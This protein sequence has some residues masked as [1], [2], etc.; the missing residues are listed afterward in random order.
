M[1]NVVPG[2]LQRLRAADIIRMAG[3]TAASLGQEYSRQGAVHQPER[4]G[5][6]LSGVIDTSHIS[7]AGSQGEDEEEGAEPGRH[8]FT[9]EVDIKSATSWESRCSCNP[10]PTQLCSHAASL[11]YYWLAHPVAFTTAP[12]TPPPSEAPKRTIHD[13]QKSVKTSQ[14]AAPVK[15]MQSDPVPVGDLL[16]MLEQMG[17]SDLRA[18]AREYDIIPNGLSRQHLAVSVQEALQQPEA[19][20]HVATTLEKAQRQLLAALILAGGVMSDDDLRGLYERFSLGQPNQYQHILMALQNKALLVRA[21]LS[22]T[23]HQRV[24]S[25]SALFDVGWY[26]PLEVRTALRVMVPVTRFQIESSEEKPDVQSSTPLHLLA[27]LLLVARALAGYRLEQQ[28]EWLERKAG[29]RANETMP[30]LR[31]PSNS[32]GS[33]PIPP[34]ADTPS[35][36]M[37]AFLQSSLKQPP[38]FLRLALHLLSMAGIV[39]QD[40]SGSPYLRVLPDAAQLLL[41]PRS[42]EAA[43]DLF[44][45]WLTRS[46][47]DALFELQEEGVRLRCRATSLNI[48]L[49]RQGDLDVEN[50][51]AL[52]LVVELLAQAPSNQWISFPA[53]ARFFY[54]LNPLFLQKRQRHFSSPHW[55]LELEEGR[56]LRPLNL[57][58]WSRAEAHYLTR[59]LRGPLHWW[60]ICDIA[61]AAD[62]RL[63]AFHLTPAASWLLHDNAPIEQEEVPNYQNLATSLEIVDSEE[64]LVTSSIHS[65]PTIDVMDQFAEAA[66]VQNSR[67]RYRL[68]PK[69]LG[70]ALSQ[71]KRATRLLDLLHQLAEEQSEENDTPLSQMLA[72]LERWIANYGRV[73]LYTGVTLVETADTL[74]MR[75][76]LATT[77]LQD[78]I[79]QSIHPTLLILKQAGAEQV[80]DDLK[81]RGQSPLLHHKDSYGT[82]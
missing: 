82:E 20:R 21:S 19:V 76:L 79:V 18:I 65:W 3:L 24:G 56:P 48:P 2:V 37:M 55:W 58:D 45:L 44:E 23:S 34:P 46:S 27:D 22:N 70:E 67:L 39:H 14:G 40:D 68:T 66:G 60:G 50:R 78:H 30:S 53:F 72:H 6:R 31:M 52:Q 62:G 51:E 74:V 33:A 25:S 10:V 38:A 61:S 11:L 43:R 7:I 64:V 77:T 26:V 54:R 47:Y 32:D 75:E 9:V 28:D 1:Q 35:P 36:A 57:S 71:G 15:A 59:L 63:L 29:G 81:R 80:I 8:T 49:I 69:A 41:G 73:R 12:E 42:Q 5:T 4:T 16:S 17:L 13:E